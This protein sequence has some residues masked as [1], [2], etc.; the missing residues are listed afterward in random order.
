MLWDW[1]ILILLLRHTVPKVPKSTRPGVP[2]L[3][4]PKSFPLL[5]DKKKL[6]VNAAQEEQN[7]C[8]KEVK[9]I[10]FKMHLTGIVAI[11]L[12]ILHVSS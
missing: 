2:K 9:R 4:K 10:A 5:N 8:T 11:K 3:R 1:N 6:R 12:T 7:N